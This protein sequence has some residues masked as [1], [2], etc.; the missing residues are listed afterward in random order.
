MADNI[1]LIFTYAIAGILV[2]GGLLMLFAT[3]LDPPET[4]IQGLRLLLSGFIGAAIQFVFNRDTQTATARQ[5]ERNYATGAAAQPNVIA[6]A[7]PPNTIT[8]T[9]QPTPE[10]EDA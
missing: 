8:V 6:S 3:R 7:G 1:K 4:D 9:P 10:V 2:V 5:V